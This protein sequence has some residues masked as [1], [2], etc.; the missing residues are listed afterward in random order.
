MGFLEE[1]F[2]SGAV[3]PVIDRRCP[4]HKTPEALR[5]LEDGLALGKVVIQMEHEN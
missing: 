3:R 4:L 2:E 1:L 5:Y